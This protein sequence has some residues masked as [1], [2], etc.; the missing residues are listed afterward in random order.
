M[1]AAVCVRF[2][3]IDLTDINSLLCNYKKNHHICAAQM[4][5]FNPD[6]LYILN[7]KKRYRDIKLRKA[8]LYYELCQF[9]DQH[10]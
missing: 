1:C 9:N 5:L 6:F 3:L 2:C 7:A 8:P 4:K 10:F